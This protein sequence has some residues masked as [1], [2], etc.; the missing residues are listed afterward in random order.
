MKRKRKP[1]LED[2]VDSIIAAQGPKG[3]LKKR[4][5]YNF[6]EEILNVIHSRGEFR[7]LRAYHFKG[8]INMWH[9]TE[10]ITNY[11]L[12]REAT[13]ELLDVLKER[14][15]WD[16]E[17]V[18]QNIRA[19]HFQNEPI[20]YNTTLC[21]MMHNIYEDSPSWAV[22]DFLQNHPDEDVRK[23]FKD[24][25]PY[26]FSDGQ[27]HIWTKKDGTKNY[28]LARQAIGEL[29]A[30]LKEKH[31]WSDEQVIE[32]INL[33]HFQN[34]PIRY[35]ATLSGMIAIVYDD[36]PSRAVIDFYRNHP[37]EEV[38]KQ[39]SDLKE[40]H[41]PKAQRHTWNKKDG[42]KNYELARQATT[43]LLDVLKEHHGWSDE[44]ATKNIAKKHFIKEPIKFNA[45]LRG[46][47][48]RVYGSRDAAIQDYLRHRK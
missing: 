46:M 20:R 48:Y 22:M 13:G 17:H 33:K 41:F 8:A 25:K 19:K 45:T 16:Y 9:T 3:A 32:N 2:H 18:I 30:K 29:I 39:F 1:T 15:G 24:L 28:E 47:L 40:Y 21:G 36:S 31:R 6:L 11:E 38:R 42:T 34:E 43:E 10:G 7:D 12:A 4:Y 26:H 37:D 23:K 5:Q 27:K 14:Y 35:N 44:K